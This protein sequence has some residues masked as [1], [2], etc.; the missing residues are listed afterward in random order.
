MAQLQLEL[1]FIK[2]EV[3]RAAAPLQ[4]RATVEMMSKILPFNEGENCCKGLFP[5]PLKA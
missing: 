4:T 1:H 3:A 2:A 5:R